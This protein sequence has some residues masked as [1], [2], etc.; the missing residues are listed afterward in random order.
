VSLAERMAH[1]LHAQKLVVIDDAG[2]LPQVEQPEVFVEAV[3][4]FV[5]RTDGVEPTPEGRFPPFGRLAVSRDQA[6]DR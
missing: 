1:D 6:D 2:H 3:E 4:A 5:A